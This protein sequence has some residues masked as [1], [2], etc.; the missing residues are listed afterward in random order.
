MRYGYPC[1][2]LTLAAE[3][4]KVNRSMIK[5]IFMEKG[6]SYAS[7]LALANNTQR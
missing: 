4:I 1:I 3:K 6:I 2:N 5:R 7:T